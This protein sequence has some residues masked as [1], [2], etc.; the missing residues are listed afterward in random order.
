MILTLDVG[1]T[2]IFGG[3][4]HDAKLILQFR[5][6]SR[7]NFSSDEVGVFLRQVLRE[8]DLD[9]GAVQGIALCSVVPD[10]IYSLRNGCIKYFS[11]D[12]FV[13]QPG[14]KTGLKIRYLNPTEVGADRIVNSIAGVQLFPGK[15]LII[16]DFGT[17]TTLDV[18]T[19]NKEYLGGAILPGLRIS[20]EALESNT[21]KLPAVELEH[22]ERAIGRTTK[23]SMQ[24]GLYFGQ[25]GTLKEL[26]RRVKQE[27]FE[28]SEPVVIGTGGFSQMFREQGLFNE[29]ISDLVLQ[30]IF[31]AYQINVTKGV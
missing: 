29:I 6:S 8:N 1:N 28:D 15:D 27:A 26:I 22:P 14:I 18:V 9:P 21:A 23:E 19:K 3:V 13:V 12:P 10:L 31:F 11:T 2:Q 24:S 5:K 17:A 25:V 16:I 30:G 4:F 7:S 20:M